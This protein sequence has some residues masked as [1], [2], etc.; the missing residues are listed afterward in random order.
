MFTMPRA[1]WSQAGWKHFDDTTIRLIE[2]VQDFIHIFPMFIMCR[3]VRLW[4]L[5]ITSTGT[6][7]LL[8][9]GTFFRLR[10]SLL[11]FGFLSIIA[12]SVL[13]E[14]NWWRLQGFQSIAKSMWFLYQGRMMVTCPLI[15]D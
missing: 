5:F 8:S 4:D 6:L 11:G 7:P 15:G 2:G 14:A 13:P 12:L 3:R 1:A 10:L 9:L